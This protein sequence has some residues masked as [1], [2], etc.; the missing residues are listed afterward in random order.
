M[1]LVVTVIV[2]LTQNMINYILGQHELC[3]D[4]SKIKDSDKRKKL[5]VRKRMM[6]YR[7]RKRVKKSE[8]ELRR[9]LELLKRWKDKR[10][11]E[12]L[13]NELKVVAESPSEEL[14]K[15]FRQRGR[16]IA[17]KIK[18]RCERCRVETSH[19]I[20]EFKD[21]RIIGSRLDK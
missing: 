12:A 21:F 2:K 7:I 8:S 4:L 14:R 17:P 13:V 1:V 3:R 18:M 10:D 9:D 19:D 11:L 5:L 6:D 15:I 16:G 20:I